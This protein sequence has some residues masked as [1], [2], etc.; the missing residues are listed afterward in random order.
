MLRL[1]CKPPPSLRPLSLRPDLRTPLA[2]LTRSYGK[3]TTCTQPP[4][5]FQWKR[6]TLLCVYR[7]LKVMHGHLSLFPSHLHRTCHVF[8]VIFPF[9]FVPHHRAGDRQIQ[10]DQ[11]QRVRFSPAGPAVQALSLPLHTLAAIAPQATASFCCSTM[12]RATT[13]SKVFSRTFTKR[14]RPL[15]APAPHLRQSP[16]NQF[17]ILTPRSCLHL[18]SYVKLLLNPFYEPNTPITSSSF[19]ARIKALVKKH[20]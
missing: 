17:V 4:P 14:E 6:V 20:L 18:G 16:L 5:F 10:R 7:Y 8:S 13:R 3:A 9:F 11:H 12:A 1:T 15:P 19:D 2:A